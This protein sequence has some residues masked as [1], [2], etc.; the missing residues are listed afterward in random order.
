MAAP[1]DASKTK[2]YIEVVGT[3]LTKRK[4]AL[5]SQHTQDRI[6]E[7]IDVFSFKIQREAMIRCPVDTGYLR[8]SIIVD[9]QEKFYNEVVATA[10]YAAFVEFG[11]RQHPAQPFMVPAA[12]MYAPAFR[13][14]IQKAM[15]WG[16]VR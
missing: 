4:I 12:Q 5:Y 14:E 13:D 15:R 1:L 2:F 11:T 6:A 8:S 10:D 3:D 9:E 7:I 16:W